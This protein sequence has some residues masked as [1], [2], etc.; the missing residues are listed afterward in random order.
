MLTLDAL[1]LGSQALFFFSSATG[2]DWSLTA[3]LDDPFRH[4]VWG[5]SLKHWSDVRVIDTVLPSPAPSLR[6]R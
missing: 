2:A 3:R 1:S 6:F 4:H 5:R